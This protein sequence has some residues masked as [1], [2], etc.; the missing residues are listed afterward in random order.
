MRKKVL[1]IYPEF[2]VTYWSLKH[3]LSFVNKKTA[4]IPLGLLTV[5]ALLP[6][7]YYVTL[8]D[9]NV[10]KLTRKKI[11]NA[12]IVFISSMIVQKKSFDEVVAL[13]NELGVPVVAGGPYPTSSYEKIS[14][15][16]YFV[17]NEAEITLPAFIRDLEEGNPGKLYLNTEKPDITKT[18]PPRFDLIDFKNYNNIAL[19]NSRGCPFNCE[20]C[21]II[22]LFGRVP[23]FKEPLQF[24]HE[25]ELVYRQGFR[26]SLF[27]VDDNFIGNKKK[28]KEL[29]RCIVDWQKERDY[30]FSLFTEAS[31]NLA[32][33]DEILNLM[34]DAG[35]DM[36]FVGI[37]TP[38]TEAL[39]SCNKN[40]NLNIDLYESVRRIQN[41]GIEVTGG[42][43]VGFD[44]DTEDIFDRQIEFIQK[45]GIPMAMV[46]ILG[47]LPNTQLYRR[48]KKEGRLKENNDFS[49]NDNQDLRMGF[50]PIIPEETII[51]GYKK[52]ISEIYNP[53]NYF[54]RCYT[55]FEHFPSERQKHKSLISVSNLRAL[56]LSFV[57][58]TF[59][60][61]SFHYL[62]FLLKVMIHKPE[63]FPMAIEHAIKGYH[64]FI[65]TEEIIKADQL[66]SQI[67]SAKEL[68]CDTFKSFVKMPALPSRQTKK[69]IKALVLFRK[70]IDKTYA[71]MSRDIQDYLREE[72]NDYISIS[73][74]F[75]LLISEAY[76]EK[77]HP[78]SAINL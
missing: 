33:D 2:P 18:P 43:I 31:I 7:D 39:K 42:F 19:Q 26:G 6:E 27:I 56:I 41:K 4:A 32:A 72:F 20:F 9:M 50:I 76:S 22:E 77:R 25:M 70:K 54:E 49:G 10:D 45:A 15:V 24:I 51:K 8:I 73:N 67:E 12:D 47:V 1:M 36:V 65:I 78:N 44:Q 28:V 63:C 34:V 40:Q 48:L 13:C 46:G 71:G 59:S 52:I 58:Q 35:F 74:K 37:E 17:L 3:A 55:F 38:D 68:I 69:L 75:L 14:G 29:L 11:L 30:P 64:F 21:D 61:Y 66:S 60:R 23:R 53:K 62:R 57:K 5:A 16:D